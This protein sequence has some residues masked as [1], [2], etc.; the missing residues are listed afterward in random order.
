MAMKANMKEMPWR[1]SIENKANRLNGNNGK[2]SISMAAMA[3]W[4]RRK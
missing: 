1:K 4:H 3:A 2:T